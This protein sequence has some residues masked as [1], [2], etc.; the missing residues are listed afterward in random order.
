MFDSWVYFVAG[1]FSFVLYRF[2]W[3]YSPNPYLNT[4]YESE[5]NRYK[6]VR[7]LGDDESF[8]LCM[9]DGLRFSRTCGVLKMKGKLD[10]GLL[11]D[12]LHVTMARH[13]CLRCG[14]HRSIYDGKFYFHEYTHAY[15][16]ATIQYIPRKSNDQ[17]KDEWYKITNFLPQASVSPN[18]LLFEFYVVTS[19][20]SREHE[21]FFHPSHV[22]VDG[23]SQYAF[24]HHLLRY[25]SLLV[26]SSSSPSNSIKATLMEKEYRSAFDKAEF[27]STFEALRNSPNMVKHLPWYHSFVPYFIQAI[28]FLSKSLF[29]KK[30]F[31]YGTPKSI[32][33]IHDRVFSHK[34]TTAETKRILETA[35][36][37]GMTVHALVH[38][39]YCE[40]HITTMGCKAGSKLLMNCPVRMG[41]FVEPKA[42]PHDKI[43]LSSGFIYVDVN[44][45]S[46]GTWLD[47]AHE[48]HHAIHVN[49]K[50]KL[51]GSA[52]KYY[53]E[54][55]VE[56]AG[57][58]HPISLAVAYADRSMQG[59][60]MHG[61][62][63]NVGDLTRHIPKTYGT[64][65]DTV[66]IEDIY[67]TQ[68]NSVHGAECFMLVA[69]LHGEMMLSLTFP[70]PLFSESQASGVWT[71]FVSKLQSLNSS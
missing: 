53:S 58:S 33:D 12:A 50:T 62:L 34:F 30:S 71:G 38:G 66:S 40:S 9:N 52:F 69:T 13:P 27:F 14:I 44:V 1:I 56:S 4:K 18:H 8:M 39:M 3:R 32:G 47:Y 49:P 7:P 10:M 31:Q 36:F 45:K 42:I 46:G 21:L 67:V 59:R 26:A 24:F 17:W 22:I 29:S 54:T 20:N 5:F 70:I 6:T 35:K 57:V 43:C 55:T 2:L 65:D 11:S 23:T 51:P 48:C 61:I 28:P 16:L 19:P 25:Y 37:Q 64:G 15:D 41:N 60:F 68:S 63:S